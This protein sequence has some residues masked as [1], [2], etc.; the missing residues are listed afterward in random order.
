MRLQQG[1]CLNRNQTNG[2]YGIWGHDIGDLV[3]ECITYCPET[4]IVSMSIES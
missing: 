1:G 3:I 4:K 2:I